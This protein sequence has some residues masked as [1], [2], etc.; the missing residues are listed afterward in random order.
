MTA[1]GDGDGGIRTW[2]PR[3]GECTAVIPSGHMGHSEAGVT[4]LAFSSDSTL[5]VTGGV[6]GS[7]VLSNVATGKPVAQVLEHTD[8][9]ESVAF[10]ATLPLVVSASMDGSA[11]IWDKSSGAR[12]GSCVHPAGV[13]AVAMQH[14]GPLVATACLD[15]AVRVFDVRSAQLVATFGGHTA[16]VQSLAWATD[17]VHIASGGDDHTV[18]VFE[19]KA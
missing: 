14:T 12:R 3:S 17:D 5:V 13:V 10:A 16:A 2:S 6:D 18:R 15:G 7:L 11:V 19:F 9:V 8:S 1:G 4:C